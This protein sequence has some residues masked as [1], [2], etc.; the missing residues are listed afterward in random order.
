MLLCNQSYY[1][2]KRKL[3]VF[4][5][6]ILIAF[7]WFDMKYFSGFNR[8][9]GRIDFCFKTNNTYRTIIWYDSG[10]ELKE[11]IQNEQS[12]VTIR[13]YENNDEIFCFNRFFYQK[14]IEKLLIA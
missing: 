8:K 6:K 11:P 10:F 14:R 4:E 3:T 1:E 13:I 12:F 2:T 5:I 9:S 7:S